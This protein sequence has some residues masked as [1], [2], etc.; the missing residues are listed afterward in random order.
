MGRRGGYSRDHSTRG[1]RGKGRSSI[2][3]HIQEHTTPPPSISVAVPTPVCTPATAATSAPV[4]TPTLATMSA[5]PVMSAMPT[6]PALPAMPVVPSTPAV[7]AMPAVPTTPAVPAMP[8]TLVHTSTTITPAHGSM[9]YASASAT[10]DP[11]SSFVREIPVSPSSHPS[12]S[13]GSSSLPQLFVGPSG[14]MYVTGDFSVSH[15]IIHVIKSKF[16]RPYSKWTTTPTEVKNQWFDEFKAGDETFKL[17]SEVGKRN[18]T[19]DVGGL[20][21]SNYYGGSRSILGH[22]RKM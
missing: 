3:I 13:S 4:C 22:K 19:S 20:G 9:A 18:R 6:M 8:A 1:G 10:S 15:A 16:D 11:I 14:H 7:P 2:G 5:V 17:Q 21:F 12:S